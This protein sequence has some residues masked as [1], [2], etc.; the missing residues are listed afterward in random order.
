MSNITIDLPTTKSKPVIVE[1]RKLTI[2]AHPKVGKTS[3]VAQLPNSLIVDLEDSAHFFES[4]SVNVKKIAAEKNLS[5]INAFLTVRKAIEEQNKANGSP[6]YDFIILDTTTVLQDLAKTVGLINYKRSPM[7]K[8]FTGNDITTLPQGAGYVWLRNAFKSLYEGFV[9]LSGKCTI[10]LAHVKDSS[11]YKN[12]ESVSARDIN[13]TGQLK[14]IVCADMDATA[15]MFRKKNSNANMLSFKNEENDLAT[16][17]RLQYL[18][19]Q[20]F[21]ISEQFEADGKTPFKSDPENPQKASVVKTYWERVFPS[22]KEKEKK[23]GKS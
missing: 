10:L 23:D 19:G 8:S 9:G 16:G 5:L 20:E 11:I 6:V 4:A 13:L 12:G 15:F 1:P 2:V 21:V 14:Q 18:A 22:L 3:N 17:S 7:G